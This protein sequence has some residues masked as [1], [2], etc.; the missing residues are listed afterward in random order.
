MTDLNGDYHVC[1]DE[2]NVRSVPAAQDGVI[3]WLAVGANVTVYDVSDGWG[4]ISPIDDVN[5]EWVN[6]KYLCK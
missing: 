4:R 6:M 5:A 1:V 3:T 2:L